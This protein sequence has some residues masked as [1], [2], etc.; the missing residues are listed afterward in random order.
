M[1]VQRTILQKPMLQPRTY[2]IGNGGKGRFVVTGVRW[3]ESMKRR[4]R[5]FAEIFYICCMY[6]S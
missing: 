1:A 3:A 5:G 2:S 4:K 6:W